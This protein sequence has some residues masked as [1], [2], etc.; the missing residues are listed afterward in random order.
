VLTDPAKSGIRSWKDLK[1]KRVA[2]QKGTAG[3]GALL[4]N[5]DNVGV[6]A[7]DVTIVDLPQTQATAAL[8]SGSA[9]AALSIEPLTSVY[10]AKHPSARI[11]AKDAELPDRSTFIIAS[12]STLDDD[13]KA[14]A[15]ADYIAR[16]V[17]SFKYV[18]EHPEKLAE[19]VYVKTY[20]LPPERAQEIVDQNGELRFFQLPGPIVEPQQ[21]LADLFAAAGSITGEVDVR[22]EFDARYNDVVAEAAGS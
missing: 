18:S 3:E 14:A 5:L 9:D 20:G 6:S 22:Q 16:L 15:L 7:D 4:Q 13:G 19:S 8:Q 12:G 1:G 17:R 10:V 2:T 21:R 11:V